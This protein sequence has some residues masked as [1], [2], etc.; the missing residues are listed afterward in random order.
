VGIDARAALSSRSCP[1]ADQR[2]ELGRTP[3]RQGAVA[4]GHLLDE[5]GLRQPV[6]DD[7]VGH[8]PQ[9]PPVVGRLHEVEAD[10][11]PLLQVERLDARQAEY[12][13]GGRLQG[14]AVHTDEVVLA[15]RDTGVLGMRRQ[16]CH[17]ILGPDD[18]SQRRVAV[19]HHLAGGLERLD[20]ELTTEVDAEGEAVARAD[21]T[22]LV[23]QPQRLLARSERMAAYRCGGGGGRGHVCHERQPGLLTL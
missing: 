23:Q 18:R 9:R 15:E 20:V 22:Y 7:V 21:L 13:G 4:A 3:E 19:D 6:E 10:E 2:R 1:Y 16:T 8:D 14:G 5:D 17:A 11:R 12:V